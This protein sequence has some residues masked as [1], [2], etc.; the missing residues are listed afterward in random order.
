MAALAFLPVADVTVAWPTIKEEFEDDEREL[1][2][3]FEKTWVGEAYVRRPGRKA[4][5]HPSSLKI[6]GFHRV[7]LSWFL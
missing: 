5:L 3:Y 7:G 6:V 2:N 4:P 1:A